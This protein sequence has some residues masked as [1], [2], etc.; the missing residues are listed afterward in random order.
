MASAIPAAISIVAAAIKSTT[1]FWV[2]AA[3]STAGFVLSQA[4]RP[5]EQEF[6]LPNTTAQDRGHLI[7]SKGT[8]EFLPLIYGRVRVGINIVFLEVSSTNNEYLHIVGTIGEGEIK[9]VYK[10]DGVDQIWLNDKL[11]NDPLYSGLVTY[12]VYNGTATQDVD[13]N[14]KAACPAWND[15]LRHTAYIYMKLKWDRNVF[16]GLPLITLEVEGLKV[17]NPST[18]MTEYSNNPALCARDYFTRSARRGGIGINSARLDDS[19]VSACASYCTAKGW[20]IGLPLI[21]QQAVTDNLSQITSTYR[22]AV[23]YSGGIFKFKYK[24]LYYE[25]PVE[26]IDERDIIS[27]GNES[28]LTISQPSIFDTPNAV[29][30]KFLDE[31]INFQMNDYVHSDDAL[32]MADGNYREETITIKGINSI[33]NAM[34]MSYYHLER[35]RINKVVDM[36]TRLRLLALEPFDIVTL[37]HNIPGWKDK[38]LRVLSTRM[39]QDGDIML[40]LI[41]EENL[42]YDDI[43]NIETHDWKDTNYVAPSTP[44]PSVGNISLEEE[45]YYYRERSFTRLKATFTP[46]SEFYPYYPFW[47]Y[48]QVWVK[49]GSGEWKYMTK[50]EGNYQ[51]DPVNEGEIYYIKFVS[52]NIWGTAEPFNNAPSISKMIVGKVTAP[53]SLSSLT[54]SV[55]GD[56]VSLAAIPISDPDIS[57]YEIRIGSSWTNAMFFGL[58]LSPFV[59][60]PGI[61]PG[62][63]TFWMAPKGNNG[64]YALTP[65]SATVTVFYPPGYVDQDIWSW[66]FSTG[67]HDNTE[68]TTYVGDN[69]LGCSHINDILTGTWTSPVYDLGSLQTSRIWG[70]FHII[71]IADQT[72]NSIAPFSTKWNMITNFSTT[73]NSLLGLE[74]LAGNIQATIY[75]GSTTDCADGNAS[76]FHIFSPEFTARYIKVAVTITDA[77]PGT[78]LYLYT[79]NMKAAYWS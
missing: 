62:T 23:T 78:H 69:V 5:S 63:H 33:T 9:G 73:W 72:W 53:T 18:G 41:E 7:N 65:R 12:T 61:K 77:T 11:Y 28:T 54:A 13:A 70:D 14:L 59:S 22:G 75:W 10:K 42:L 17:Y 26:D 16:Q 76:F 46:P 58:F 55:T 56:T 1:T 64:V 4:L 25:T 52:V 68:K 35:Y 43:W 44:P 71:I 60:K 67:T 24:D 57:G 19:S 36:M 6:D 8:N 74:E 48:A 37:T 21:E 39:T 29:R 51:I 49:I 79:L 38:Y 27:N 66:D 2:I 30:I 50:V 31:E 40:N 34:K 3:L 47:D 32:V 45:V 15:A 20:T